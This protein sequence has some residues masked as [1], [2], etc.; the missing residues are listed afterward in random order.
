MVIVVVEVVVAAVLVL[1]LSQLPTTM[2]N[3]SE[4]Q[5]LQDL[6][7]SVLARLDCLEAK[8]GVS[9]APAA[10]SK[11]AAPPPPPPSLAIP[12]SDGSPAVKAYDEFLESSV[13]LMENACNALGG[14]KEMGTL[15][16]EAWSSIATIIAIASRAKKPADVPAELQ[17]LLGKT[18]DCIKQMQALRL[19]RDYDFHCKAILESNAALSWILIAP[20][21]QTPAAF[22]KEAASSTEF[23]S[24]RI[25]KQYK[26]KDDKQIAF[27]DA[28][29]TMLADLV[30]YI[31]E[32]HKTG[33]T[34]NPKGVSVAEAAIVVADSAS[35]PP[36]SGA[37]DAA[38]RSPRPYINKVSGGSG[39]MSSLVAELA[40]KRTAD[41]SSA[42]TGLKHV[43]IL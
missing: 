23:W 36:S 42:A 28:L 21:P 34:W 1:S 17:P 35:S 27:C 37:P 8:V 33:L 10:T 16:T 3:K 32:Y 30:T 5:P 20:P 6:L 39:G 13:T 14:M 9:A 24:N 19:D 40:S 2:S 29:K 11:K 12:S 15:V 38:P 25:R 22:V 43:R 41:G 4:L 7:D 26:G 18:Q 31:S